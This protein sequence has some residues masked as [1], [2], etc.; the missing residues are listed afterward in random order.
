MSFILFPHTGAPRWCSSSVINKS[1]SN[2][3]SS[4]L[5]RFIRL[6]YVLNSKLG[7][8]F[9]KLKFGLVFIMFFK[10]SIIA[11]DGDIYN[12]FLSLYSY[13]NLNDT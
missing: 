6:W 3:D 12:T 11:S 8:S 1:T 13:A 10:C 4:S 7:K 5:D 9:S 2:L